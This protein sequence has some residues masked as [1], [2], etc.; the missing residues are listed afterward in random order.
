[1]ND[2]SKQLPG[3][4]VAAISLCL[5]VPPAANAQQPALTK[6]QIQQQHDSA[7]KKC[8]VLKNNA[9]KICEVEA[10]G[11]KSIAEAQARVMDRDSPKNRLNLA[12]TRADAE[13]EVAKARCDDQVGES[14]DTCRRNAKATRDKAKEQAKRD[15]QTHTQA[16]PD[17]GVTD[18]KR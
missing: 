7:M 11:E 5:L 14:K 12:E 16:P 8:D 10:D 13:F 4:A 6:R 18:T 9:K 1:M 2:W 15:S 17:S 3:I